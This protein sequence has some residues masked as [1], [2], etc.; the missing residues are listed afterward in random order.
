MEVNFG[1]HCAKSCLPVVIGCGLEQ[2]IYDHLDFGVNWPLVSQLYSP[3]PPQVIFDGL[4]LYPAS[5]KSLA[6]TVAMPTFFASLDTKI[7]SSKFSPLVTEGSI[8]KQLGY[9]QPG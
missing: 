8:D 4:F 1:I 3:R 9:P 5:L 6:V 7:A 2:V